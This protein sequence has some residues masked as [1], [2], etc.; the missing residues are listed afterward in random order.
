MGLDAFVFCN[1]FE[2]GQIK[3][4]P[5]P[6]WGVIVTDDGQ[7]ECS[8]HD[9]DAQQAFEEWRMNEACQHKDCIL[10]GHSIGNISWVASLRASLDG[11][12]IA[13]PIILDKVLYSGSHCGDWLDISTVQ[14][15]QQEL[16]ALRHIH[17]QQPQDEDQLRTF[18]RQMQE[19]VEAALAAGNPICF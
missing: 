1:C 8:S 16:D 5:N 13:L 10:L 11:I 15:L 14:D 7:I 19:L 4:E 17:L 12:S 9:L 6:E 2:T 3:V 18:A